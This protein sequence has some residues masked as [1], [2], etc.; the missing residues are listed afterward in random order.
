[1]L[2]KR[3]LSKHMND[4]DKIEKILAFL[5][6][7]SGSHD[8]TIFRQE[9]RDDLGL[10]VEHPSEELYDI[11]KKIQDNISKE[12]ELEQAYNPGIMMA[13][14]KAIDYKFRRALIESVKG[15]SHRFI[16]SGKLTKFQHPGAVAEEI[17]DDRTFEGW[18]YEHN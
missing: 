2:G 3:L 12:L 14:Q 18:T 4:G 9:A 6:S 1:M 15:G 7:E 16:S 13:G 11:I 17:R 5:C 10:K 8:Y